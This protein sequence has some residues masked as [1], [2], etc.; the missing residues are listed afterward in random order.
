MTLHASRAIPT[1]GFID[2][3]IMSNN[4][5]R[6]IYIMIFRFSLRNKNIQLKHQSL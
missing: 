5:H 3:N 4:I 6:T 1:N 2:N